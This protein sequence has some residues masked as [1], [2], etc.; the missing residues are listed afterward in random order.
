[1]NTA[2]A[3]KVFRLRKQAENITIETL[4]SVR[5]IK[6]KIQSV[7]LSNLESNVNILK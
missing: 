4:Y 6:L 3:A 1:M 7:E 5:F 2:K